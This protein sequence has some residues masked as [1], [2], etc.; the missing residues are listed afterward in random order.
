MTDV[1]F[2]YLQRL[3]ENPIYN[4]TSIPKVLRTIRSLLFILLLTA[5][6]AS[7]QTNEPQVRPMSEPKTYVGQDL[8]YG[9]GL[10]L[11]IDNFGFGL[12]GQYRRVIGPYS[13]LTATLD[14]TGVRDVSE[15]KF[16]FF[17]QQVI[18]N[19]YRRVVAVPMLLGY[20]QRFF[21]DKIDDNFRLYASVEGG[22]IW[23]AVIPYF[24]DVNGNGFRDVLRTREFIYREPVNDI[25][26]GWKDAEDQW[27]VA[28]RLKIGVDFGENFSKLSSV[29]FGYNFY[30]F[31]EGIQMMEP[32][33]A[34]RGPNGQPIPRDDLFGYEQC[35]CTYH[36][37]MSY[38]GTPQISLVFGSFW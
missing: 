10:H 17:D 22:A 11:F 38:F 23:A 37:P 36:E 9:I 15:Q 1:E 16:Q 34:K 31:P 5:G 25:F 27:G 24:K 6:V 7:A 21:A 32:K 3:G 12:G 13:Q 28:G 18:P 29:E 26:Q 20:K 33:R 35:D 4:M 30:Y 8:D 19:K 2:Q 14:I